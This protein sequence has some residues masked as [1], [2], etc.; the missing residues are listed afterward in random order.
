MANPETVKR[1]RFEDVLQY[2]TMTY[3]EWVAQY[4]N[5]AMFAVEGT[6]GILYDVT[7]WISELNITHNELDGEGAGRDKKTGKMKRV[8]ITVKHDLQIKVVDGVPGSIAKKL[9]NLVDTVESENKYSF[10]VWYHFPCSDGLTTGTFYSSTQ[11][12]GAQ[13]YSKSDG[14]C[15]YTGMNFKVIEM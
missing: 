13:R 14:R 8:Y 5:Y 15:Y 4:G 6:D 12:Y 9:H 7:E 2:D 3:D 10:R 1:M 11:N